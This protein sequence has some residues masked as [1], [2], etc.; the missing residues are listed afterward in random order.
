MASTAISPTLRLL[1]PGLRPPTAGPG[2]QSTAYGPADKRREQREDA[3]AGEERPQVLRGVVREAGQRHTAEVVYETQ[4]QQRSYAR[5]DYRDHQGQHGDQKAV[6]EARAA[7]KTPRDVAADDEGQEQ[8]KQEPYEARRP[9]LR[10]R[11][12]RPSAS[13]YRSDYCSDDAAEDQAAPSAASQ[14]NI[15]LSQL[16]PRLSLPS[17]CASLPRCA[18]RELCP[19]PRGLC[20]SR[21]TPARLG[22]SSR[23]PSILCPSA[24]MSG[25]SGR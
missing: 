13:Q 8:R 18:S 2:A 14:P 16:V 7:R 20:S 25:P 17:R 22:P 9:A 15:T 11:R 24:S 23:G 10:G 19:S 4:A 3:R 12:A 21:T 6:L 5:K 1:D